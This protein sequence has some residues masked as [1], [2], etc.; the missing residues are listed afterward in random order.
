MAK[1]L[2]TFAPTQEEVIRF[3]NTTKLHP[4]VVQNWIK[5]ASEATEP[6]ESETYARRKPFLAQIK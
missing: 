5:V 3:L 1:K 2:D 6:A 4:Y